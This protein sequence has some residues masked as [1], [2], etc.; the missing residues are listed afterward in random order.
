MSPF[1][2]ARAKLEWIQRTTPKRLRDLGYDLCEEIKIAQ[3]YP[4]FD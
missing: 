3:N 4:Y 1:L 2:K